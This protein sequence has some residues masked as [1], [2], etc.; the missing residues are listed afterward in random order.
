MK[1][2]DDGLYGLLTIK[3]VAKKFKVS[4]RTVRRWATQGA[5]RILLNQRVIRY[6]LTDLTQ[7]VRMRLQEAAQEKGIEMI[8]YQPTE[9]GDKR[10]KIRRVK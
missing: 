7:W 1:R 4:E 5:P 3:E 9:K 10:P 6:R 2:I 8:S